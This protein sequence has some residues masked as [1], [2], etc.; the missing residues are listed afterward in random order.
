[1]VLMAVDDLADK[2]HNGKAEKP[3]EGMDLNEKLDTIKVSQCLMS[4]DWL[5]CPNLA[6]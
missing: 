3:L 1:M 2:C 5:M 6:R 4:I